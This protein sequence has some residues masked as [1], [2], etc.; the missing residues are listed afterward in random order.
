MPARTV[1]LSHESPC[2]CCM[3]NVA[4]LT[5]KKQTTL[6]LTLEQCKGTFISTYILLRLNQLHMDSEAWCYVSIMLP[7]HRCSSDGQ[8]SIDGAPVPLECLHMYFHHWLVLF[9]D[10]PALSYPSGSEEEAYPLKIYHIARR[11]L[12][13][14]WL[15][16]LPRRSQE[17]SCRWIAWSQQRHQRL[18]WDG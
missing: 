7:E 1:G 15:L 2:R 6:Q 11:T 16:T 3:C 5:T 9:A 18:Q 8:D 17:E 13:S 10:F 14:A 12:T 4:Q